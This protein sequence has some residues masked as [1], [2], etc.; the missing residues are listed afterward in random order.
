MLKVRTVVDSDVAAFLRSLP[1]VF[2]AIKLNIVIWHLTLRR[3]SH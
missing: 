3:S 1:K 2:V